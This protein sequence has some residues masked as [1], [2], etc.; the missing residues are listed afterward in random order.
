MASLMD[1][2]DSHES[3]IGQAQGDVQQN[4]LSRLLMAPSGLATG[5]GN[6]GNIYRLCNN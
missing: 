5:P 2:K 6:M 4:R 1:G 3:A